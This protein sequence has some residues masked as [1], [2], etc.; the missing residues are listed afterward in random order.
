MDWIPA[1]LAGLPIAIVGSLMV[2]LSWPAKWA[3]PVGWASAALIAGLWWNMPVRWVA[4]STIAGFINALDILLIV[5]GALLILQTLRKSGALEAISFSMSS[6]SKDRRIQAIIIAWLMV[7]FLEGAAGFGTPAAIAAPLLVGLG[8]PPLVAVICTL[9][10]DSTAVTFGAVGVPIWGGFE[11]VRDLVGL[12]PGGD[13]TD[14]LR[15]VGSFSAILHLAAGIFM[16]LVIVCTMTRIATGS[17]RQGLQ[18]W[19]AALLAGI[20]FAVPQALIA[21]FVSF[22]VPALLGALAA[23]PIF[24]LA[25][26]SR[27]LAPRQ[28][29]DFPSRDRWPEEWEGEIAAGHGEKPRYRQLGQWKAWLP[30]AIVGAVLTFTRLDLFGLTPM[31][32]SVTIT[33]SHI[34][35]TNVSGGIAPLYNPGILPFLPVALAIPLMHG[36]DRRGT[37]EALRETM[38]MIGPAAIA[39]F[40]ALAM[41]YVMIHSGSASPRD[42]MLLVMAEAAAATV[43]GI[44]YLA[45]P[46]VGALGS[47]ISGS[48]TV[49]NIMFGVFQLDTAEQVGLPVAPVLALQAVGGAAGNMIAVHNIVAVLTT[50]GLLGKEGIVI[51]KNLPVALAYALVTGLAGWILISVV[52]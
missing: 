32:R 27:F 2:F 35:G 4:A 14:F 20:V 26:R 3:M 6:V 22:E 1:I 7:S 46:L 43:G 13:F 15:I 16:P 24:L 40:F 31:L 38:K 23:L 47:F 51:R 48:N 8:F 50:V 28:I 52:S 37:V 29:W 44:W 10:G 9:I 12:P 25:V 18:V 36:I 21:A 49:S 41:V 30:Y 33:W 34:L 45:A 19:P 17:F 5:L 11:P 39:L 42:S